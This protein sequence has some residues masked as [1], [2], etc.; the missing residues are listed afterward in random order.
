VAHPAAMSSVQ[1]PRA[2]LPCA[3]PR[4][5]S[6][7][8]A[9]DS[10]ARSSTSP[11]APRCSRVRCRTRRPAP[12]ATGVGPSTGQPPAQSPHLLAAHDCG[13][14]GNIT[15]AAV[16]AGDKVRLHKT[17]CAFRAPGGGGAAAAAASSEPSGW[18]CS[19]SPAR[20][21]AARP[22]LRPCHGPA[23]KPPHT[24]AFTSLGPATKGATVDRSSLGETRLPC[25]AGPGDSV[26]ERRCA[27]TPAFARSQHPRPPGSECN[28]VNSS[29]VCTSTT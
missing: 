6:A 8:G 27:L 10:A 7:A 28:R 18:R 13:R 22:V 3:A 16:D 19:G 26:A 20:S 4:A 5:V 9:R 24:R 14:L 29:P 2:S 12:P 1:S 15:R 23:V 11:S 17:Q 21:Q 25:Q